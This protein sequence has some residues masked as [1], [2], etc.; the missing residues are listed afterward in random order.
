M[1]R[2]LLLCLFILSFLSFL[3]AQNVSFEKVDFKFIQFPNNKLPQNSKNIKVEVILLYKDSVENLISIN[4]T[5]KQ[6]VANENQQ[7]QEEY[8]SKS[9]AEKAA[10]AVILKEGKPEDEVYMDIYIPIVYDAETLK[11]K[12]LNVEGFTYSDNY[13][14]KISVLLDG[15]KYDKET[16]MSSSL[17]PKSYYYATRCSNG[18]KALVYNNKDSVIYRE[19][20]FDLN[21]RDLK[22]SEWKSSLSAA[23]KDWGQNKLTYLKTFD[24]GMM[25]ANMNE[26]SKIIINNYGYSVVERTSLVAKIKASKFEYPEY[27][28]AYENM[29]L[30]LNLLYDKTKTEEAEKYLNDAITA[31]TG[32][33]KESDLNDKKARINKEVTAATYLNIAEAYIWL[34]NFDEAEKLLNKVI[35]IGEYKSKAEDLKAI[36]Q[37][38][39]VRYL[40]INY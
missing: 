2:F 18:V 40:N 6:Q 12:Y 24:E 14:F 26:V 11:A 5:Y 31:W 10:S 9:F 17:D 23:Q 19:Y 15:F 36:L 27:E 39:K 21:E 20:F 28:L 25:E 3:N 30:G 37:Q 33:L 34:N 38:Q 1:K 4:E 7:T 29:V 35:V 8:D 32:A 16:E 22:S 13:D